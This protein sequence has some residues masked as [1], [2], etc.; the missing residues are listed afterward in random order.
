M[1]WLD[2]LKPKGPTGPPDN[3]PGRKTTVRPPNKPKP[4]KE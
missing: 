4:P 1:S 3:R 2:W